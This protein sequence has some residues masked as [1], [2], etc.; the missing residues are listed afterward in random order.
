MSK[1]IVTSEVGPNTHE[2]LYILHGKSDWHS[3]LLG[4][5]TTSNQVRNLKLDYALVNLA[6]DN[7][8]NLIGD[9]NGDGIADF[10]VSDSARDAMYIIFGFN[11]LYQEAQ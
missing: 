1:T 2:D 9:I 6:H 3:G 8:I 7:A 10:T 4:W 11:S 5:G